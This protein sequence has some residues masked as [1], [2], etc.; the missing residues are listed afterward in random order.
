M[1]L[2]PM[3]IPPVPAETARV[4]QAAFPKGNIYMKLCERVG[5]ILHDEDFAPLFAKDGTPGLPP[6]R[7]ALVTILQFHENLSDRQAAEAVRARI[8]W[9]YVLSLELTDAGFDFSVLSE[10]RA[11][12]LKGGAEELLLERLL[13]CCRALGLVKARG[14]QRTDSTHVVAAV[15]L[16]HRLELVGETLRA[17]LNDLAVQ[18][19]DWVRAVTPA[20]WYERYQRR[21]EHGRLPKGKEARDSYAKTIGEDGFYLL[22]MLAAATTPPHLRELPSVKTLE[23][24]WSQQYERTTEPKSSG[25]SSGHRPVRWKALRELPRATKQ[26]ESPYDLD[27]RYRTKRDTHGVGYMVHYTETCDQ[28]QVS[29]ITH[30]HTT[31]ATVP[32]S[33]C[34]ALIQDALA[35]RQLTPREQIVDSADIDAELLVKSAQAHHTILV[36]P[37]RPKAGWQNTVAGAYGYD[38]FTVDWNRKQVQCPQGKWSLPWH[39]RRDP[40]RDPW[41]AAH[42]RRQDCAACPTRSLC[43][44]SPHQA[45]FFKLLPREQHDALQ[46]ARAMHTTEAGQKRYAQRAG[47]EGTIAQSVRSF[48]ARRTRYRGLPKTHL[49]Q[50]ITAVAINV[51]RIVAWFD[52]VPKATTRT[53]HFA[54]LAA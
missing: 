1:S 30:V 46:Q 19:P 31:P 49:Q 36:G 9:K 16:M 42:F 28:K 52:E 21:I 14:Q 12:L 10:F 40:S 54:A 13:E 29:L 39:E 43:T 3:A 27:A 5:T 6:W 11:R 25:Q 4:A 22:D 37:A 24:I 8:D 18:V 53:S 7:L 20:D 2:K 23:V 17:T 38:Q 32:D 50:V 48:G 34:T 41:F 35:A 26:L 15:R 44:R 47:I 51:R 45:R 33:Q